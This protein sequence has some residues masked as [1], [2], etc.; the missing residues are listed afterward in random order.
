MSFTESGGTV[1]VDV[2]TEAGC[3]WT[4]ATD[5]NW[6]GVG[7]VGQGRDRLL[8]SLPQTPAVARSA[9]AH[10]RKRGEHQRG[11]LAAPLRVHRDA[12]SLTFDAGGGA[13]P[14]SVTTGADVLGDNELRGWTTERGRH[15][16]G[17]VNVTAIGNPGD[18]RDTL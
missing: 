9:T 2:T 17:I 3:A 6:V 15:R 5:A 11:W 4:T 12:Y 16:V 13:I 1:A 8:L 18:A 10:R 14:V 7:R